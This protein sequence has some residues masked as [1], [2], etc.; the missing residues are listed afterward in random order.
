MTATFVNVDR[1]SVALYVGLSMV[2]LG[3]GI[4]ASIL[5]AT[6]WAWRRLE[7]Q[8]VH[9]CRAWLMRAG[10]FVLAFNGGW[11]VYDMSW[12]VRHTGI[13]LQ[14]GLR[15]LR[16][17]YGVGRGD[18]VAIG[19]WALYM[20]VTVARAPN[21]TFS[22]TTLEAVGGLLGVAALATVG[23]GVMLGWRSW[24]RQIVLAAMAGAIL[25]LGWY[26][27]LWC[28]A[29]TVETNAASS[30]D[31]DQVAGLGLVLLGIVSFVALS[32][33]LM[34]GGGAGYVVRR[35]CTRHGSA[36]TPPAQP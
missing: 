16:G 35:L 36:T 7:L 12:L 8:G 10:A 15:E 9:G 23:F 11:L 14:P 5:L 30:A 29:A 31:G 32:L 3:L 24:W 33:L 21:Q 19:A 28:V 34:F 6:R 4:W 20:C 2:A 17:R 18:V 1:S 22:T 26:V 25:L 13:F 27:A